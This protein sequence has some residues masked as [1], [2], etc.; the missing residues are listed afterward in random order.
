MYNNNER[1]HSHYN[2]ENFK[3]ACK[4]K[5]L[6]YIPNPVLADADK[7]FNLRSKKQILDFIGNNGLENLHYLYSNEW[8]NNPNRNIIIMIDNYEFTSL[9]KLGLI[10]FRYNNE[11]NKW[12]IKSFHL[13]NNMNDAMR[14]A[15]NKADIIRK[16]GGEI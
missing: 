12:I 4:N 1:N 13:S 7:Y 8:K 11:N 14:N 6:I 15:I 10:A 3:E 2:F 5:D 16:L 9:G